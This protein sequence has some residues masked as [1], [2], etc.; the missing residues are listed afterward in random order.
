MLKNR[1]RQLRANE[2][3][4]RGRFFDEAGR[5]TD[6]VSADVDGTTFVVSTA[7]ASPGRRLFRSRSRAEFKLLRR[8]CDRIEPHGVFV[9]LGANIGT[10]TIPAL[11]YFERVLAVEAE[12]RNARLLRANVALNGVE[13][14]VTVREI[15]CSSGRGEVAFRLS[16]AKHGHHAVK[17]VK[18]GSEMLSVPSAS[19]DELLAEEGL[20]TGDIGLVWLDLEGHEP[21]A[22]RGATSILDTSIPLVVE[23]RRRT[24]AAVQELLTG[25][26]ARLVDLRAESEFPVAE[27]LSYLERLVAGGGRKFTDVLALR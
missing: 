24:A 12:P 5:Y 26:Y 21:D 14:R 17:S 6:Y 19:L 23:I 9:D 10:T 15:A 3:E 22:L 27:L 1:L 11:R 20:R 13:D 4:R 7:D 2:N 16:R 8:A 18:P 25:H